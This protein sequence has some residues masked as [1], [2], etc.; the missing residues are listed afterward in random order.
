[1]INNGNHL[2]RIELIN[3]T[4]RTERICDLPEHDA[5]FLSICICDKNFSDEMII[6]GT[7]KGNVMGWNYFKNQVYHYYGLNN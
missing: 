1:M 4:F 5:K 6:T 7:D 3:D 2:S